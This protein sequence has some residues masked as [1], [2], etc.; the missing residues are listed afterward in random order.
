MVF[1]RVIELGKQ[2][3]HGR[4]IARHLEIAVQGVKEPQRRVG[5]VV[6]ALLVSFGKQVGDQAVA[7]VVR[8]RAQDVA[9][10]VDAPGGQREPLQADHRVAAPVGEPVVAGNHGAGFVAGGMCARFVFDAPGRRDH[11]LI[12]GEHEFRRG[13][14]GQHGV[15]GQ[16][17]APAA[18]ELSDT[19][20]SG[21]ERR[22]RFE[23]LGRRHQRDR[24]ALR[25]IDPEIARTPR[26]AAGLIASALFDPVVEMLQRRHVDG[27][28]T[29]SALN[30]QPERRDVRREQ[31]LETTFAGHQR[32]RPRQRMIH[33]CL[34]R[35]RVQQRAEAKPHPPVASEQRVG[36]DH[37]VL[38]AGQHEPLLEREPLN[39]EHPDRQAGLE[40]ELVKSVRALDV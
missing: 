34:V 38:E 17:Q 27:E 13:M 32:R 10:F 28:G 18:L 36:H 14:V 8:E 39:L 25:E 12:R 33:G 3:L 20:F 19:G 11:K 30:Q 26:I 6:E 24:F 5:G 21:R 9:A 1:D 4:P 23:R 7:E 16:Q 40:P 15:R 29:G 37:G 31:H 2:Q 22:H 35:T